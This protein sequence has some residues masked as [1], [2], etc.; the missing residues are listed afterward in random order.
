MRCGKPYP[1][2]LERQMIPAL[3]VL[4][5]YFRISL[6]PIFNLYLSI[7]YFLYM[8]L[9]FTLCNFLVRI[10]KWFKK[11]KNCQ[12]KVEKATPKCCILMAVG[13]FFSLQPRLPKTAQTSFL[14]YK[15][16][17]PIVSAKQVS[18]PI[19]HNHIKREVCEPF[20]RSQPWRL[21]QPENCSKILEDASALT[22]DVD[23]FSGLSDAGNNC[24]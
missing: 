13:R 18:A 11:K 8:L 2:T 16:F 5:T 19:Y 14:F 15:L 20:R 7:Q 24:G 10:L 3:C 23:A 12:Q 22:F 21:A 1:E 17:Y 6:Q 4:E 9:S